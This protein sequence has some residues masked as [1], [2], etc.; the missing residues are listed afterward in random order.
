MGRVIAKTRMP[1]FLLHGR[2]DPFVPFRE[3]ERLAAASRRRGAGST[4]LFIARFLGHVDPGAGSEG[5]GWSRFLEALR[6]AGFVS[7]MITAMEGGYAG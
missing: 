3:S 1:V 6:L 7:R 2:S 5:G 4:R